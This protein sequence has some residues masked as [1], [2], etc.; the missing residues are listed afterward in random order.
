MVYSTVDTD[1]GS[2]GSAGT[3]LTPT[4]GTA[5]SGDDV[6][7]HVV[8]TVPDITLG[9]VGDWALI[10]QHTGP[11]YR[12]ALFHHTL[13][14]TDDLVMDWT[15]DSNY[16]WQVLACGGLEADPVEVNELA[17]TTSAASLPR[18]LGVA[19]T[20]H[21]L[22]FTGAVNV[23]SKTVVKAGPDVGFITSEATEF[24]A[25]RPAL[26]CGQ[27][28]GPYGDTTETVTASVYFDPPPT[29]SIGHTVAVAVA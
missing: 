7:C 20:D 19:E 5:G 27:F 12:S 6:F 29:H 3:T 15:T 21:A 4:V 8:W 9:D 24:A 10:Q 23:S 11:S 16:T 28:S 17:E 2:S 22:C 1:G 25:A 18:L 26:W 13:T 14:G